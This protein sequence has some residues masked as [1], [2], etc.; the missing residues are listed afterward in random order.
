MPKQDQEQNSR[1]EEMENKRAAILADL[2]KDELWSKV[3]ALK[4]TLEM[5]ERDMQEE[6]KF[7]RKVMVRIMKEE[8]EKKGL[9]REPTMEELFFPDDEGTYDFTTS[10]TS[11]RKYREHSWRCEEAHDVLSDKS[12]DGKTG[13]AGCRYSN[14]FQIGNFSTFL[15]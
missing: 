2:E 14:L 15:A 9:M 10:L 5:Q 12:R 13:R 7:T 8:E 11:R 3:L 4:R 1:G 6:V